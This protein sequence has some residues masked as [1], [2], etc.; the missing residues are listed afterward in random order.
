MFGAISAKVAK[1][2]NQLWLFFENSERDLSIDHFEC[3]D[4]RPS[5]ILLSKG[6]EKI[7][8]Q[9]SLR[10]YF[11]LPVREHLQFLGFLF[12]FD[13]FLKLNFPAFFSFGSKVG[14]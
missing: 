3:P 14:G 13:L 12:K 11:V 9:P 4:T 2:A 7:Q 10:T 8:S 5:T 6:R 1:F